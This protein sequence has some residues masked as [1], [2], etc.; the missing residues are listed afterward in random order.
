[1]FGAPPPPLS[2]FRDVRVRAHGTI[3]APTCTVELVCTY[4]H[5]GY[6]VHV[7]AQEGRLMRLSNSV[8]LG[9]ALRDQRRSL[10]MTQARLAILAGVSRR[11]LSDLEAGK[12]TTEIGL[13]F[14]VVAAL[15][16]L[17]DLR[18]EPEDSIDLD[19]HLDSLGR[20]G[21]P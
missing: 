8:D 18:T 1:M 9:F 11:W 17:L 4:A 19:T 5:I 13:V 14:K 16:L 6:S 10:S 7:R 12:P 20:D 15:G 21:D 3:C 2:L